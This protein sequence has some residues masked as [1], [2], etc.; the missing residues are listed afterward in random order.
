M[1]VQPPQRTLG[2]ISDL[3]RHLP[4]DWW[5]SLFNAIYLKTDGDVTENVEATRQEIDAVTTASEISK[6]KRILDLCCGQGRHTLEL[7]RRG[8]KH[9]TGVDRS[10]YLI[11]LARRRARAQKLEVHFKEGDARKFSLPDNAFDAVLIMGNSF[12]YFEREE[13]DLSVL[14]AVR[15]VMVSSGTLVMDVTDGDWMR[16]HY[17]PRSWE[18]IDGDQL[19]CRER[20]LA[21]DRKRLIS[22]EVVI[23]AEKGVIAD[24]FYAERLYSANGLRELLEAAGFRDIAF[25]DELTGLSDRTDAEG[26]DLGMMARRLLMTCTAPEKKAATVKGPH[27]PEVT[28]LLGDPRQPDSVKLGGQFNPEDLDT[29]RKLKHALGRLPGYK[30]AYL[31]DHAKMRDDL[32]AHRPD[33]VL[34]L[35]DEGFNNHAT[36]EL[37]V[38]AM[39]ETLGIPYSGAGPAALGLCYD[40][41]IVR[42]VAQQWEIPVP[43]ETYVD[44][45]DQG[46]TLPS[47]FPALIKPAL[48]DSSIGITKNA[49]VERPE[50]MVEY[51]NEL[52]RTLPGRAALVQEFLNGAEYS[53]ALIGNPG[54]GFITLPVLEVD[55]S[56]LPQNLPKLLGYESKWQPDS[57]Y[58]TDIKYREADLESD[59]ERMLSDWS[60]VLFQRLGC[61]DYARFDFR[62]DGNGVIKLLEVNP[63]PGWCWDGKFN[64]MAA[65]QNLSYADLLR[66]ILEAAQNR[67]LRETSARGSARRQARAAVG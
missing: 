9:V 59:R 65:F 57:P 60:A 12:G 63:N 35:C 56:G 62:T 28:V 24:Q 20:S 14:T 6:D 53:V 27:Y 25:H 61:R 47:V 52:R 44:A 41:S 45:D 21:S 17:E 55:Y 42:A 26:K 46:A 2:P 19:V 5:R 40:K 22:R 4:A 36:Q 3:E 67:V 43:L 58:W 37:H 11:R 38:P 13:D 31:D 29:V 8:F 48:G 10:R 16:S 51:L 64:L 54:M 33:F 15:R 18:W 7:A 66:L 39:L 30:F 32:I 49:V 23:H 1:A 34:N 50:Q